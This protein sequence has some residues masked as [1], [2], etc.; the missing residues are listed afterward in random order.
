VACLWQALKSDIFFSRGYIMKHVSS[1]ASQ[2]TTQTLSA[3][4]EV[5]KNAEKTQTGSTASGTSLN[6]SDVTV[7]K[8]AYTQAK[9][10]SYETMD[11][12]TLRKTGLALLHQLDI[13][14]TKK[15]NE[16]VPDSN[17]PQRLARAKQYTT[18]SFQNFLL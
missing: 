16:E 1:S 15:A 13:A 5:N 14:G 10:D 2:I 3:Y 12:N 4:R 9:F 8:Q 7:S 11:R 6:R 18:N 17:D